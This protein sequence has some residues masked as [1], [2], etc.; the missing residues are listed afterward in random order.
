MSG[1][2]GRGTV[3]TRGRL[4]WAIVSRD[5]KQ[6][7]RHGLLLII[8]LSIIIAIVGLVFFGMAKDQFEKTGVPT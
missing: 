6:I 2:G 1:N 3:P 4:I 7:R 8:S 5:M